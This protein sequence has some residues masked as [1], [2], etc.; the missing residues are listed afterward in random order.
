[1]F[2]DLP[3]VAPDGP[4]DAT[5]RDRR[6]PASRRLVTVKGQATDARF[7]D[8]VGRSSGRVHPSGSTRIHIQRRPE[9]R[10]QLGMIKRIA[11]PIDRRFQGRALMDGAAGSALVAGAKGC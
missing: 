7:V 5:G 3:L 8:R 9:V 11:P 6:H 2:F 1:M 10:G 4:R